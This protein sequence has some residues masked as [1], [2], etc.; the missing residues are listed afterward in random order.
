MARMVLNV[1]MELVSCQPTSEQLAWGKR[2]KEK[3]R[4]MREV[5]VKCYRRTHQFAT[6]PITRTSLYYGDDDGR[7][8]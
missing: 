6:M 2:Y 4:K 5:M 1:G 8:E 3:A 7:A